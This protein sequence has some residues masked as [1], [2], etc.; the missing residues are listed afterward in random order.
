MS[1][2]AAFF[3]KAVLAFGAAALSVGAVLFMF[4]KTPPLRAPITGAME[5]ID[6]RTGVYVGA[7]GEL[8]LVAPA[9]SSGFRRYSLDAYGAATS[10]SAEVLTGRM[11]EAGLKRKA[12]QPY[13]VSSIDIDRSVPLAGWLFEPPAP[14]A[15]VV[16]LHGSGD[17]DRE[18]GWY[19]YLAHFIATNGYVVL[20][21]DKRGAGR[22][23]GDW[24]SEP[25]TV[26]AQD[27]ADWL[28]ALRW[29]YPQL[30]SFGVI[31]VSQGGMIAPTTARIADAEFAIGLSVT[32][33]SLNEQLLAEIG[34][35]VE[36]A[37]VPEF[38]RSAITAIYAQRAKNRNSA[39]WRKNGTFNTL[40]EWSKWGGSFRIAL[41]RG[42]EDQFVP[43]AESVRRLER[44]D[45]DDGR[46]EW[47]VYDGVRHSL[48][49][50]DGPE[51]NAFHR[52]FQRDLIG[53]LGE[54]AR[55]AK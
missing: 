53:W 21:P 5:P 43:V 17:S 51:K 7:A 49:Y 46:L 13:A 12:D 16:I 3:I 54:H 35:D 44:A 40:T 48:C 6:T 37:G 24:R 22:S 42:D 4:P 36:E 1:R 25:L 2:R 11:E 47:R 33:T 20:L 50:P 31:G 23:G 45:N 32:A 39:F 18:N 52:D 14:K 34:N 9:L 55:A 8:F 10:L 29:R 19:V 30:S 15:A 41:G 28:N 27:G 38:L 26:L